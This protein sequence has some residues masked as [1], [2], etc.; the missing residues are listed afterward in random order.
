MAK[1][2]FL[3]SVM[4]AGKKSSRA[5]NSLV[6]GVYKPNQGR[7]GAVRSAKRSYKIITK[8]PKLF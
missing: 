3:A 7:G 2:G 1:K 8:K 6:R 4:G 5:T